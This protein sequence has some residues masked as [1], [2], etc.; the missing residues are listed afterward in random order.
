MSERLNNLISEAFL[1]Y[2]PER[3][4]VAVSGG[5]DS[6]ALLDLLQIFCTAEG[7]T[8]HAATVDHGL[9]EGSA[10]EA[11]IVAD[12]CKRIGIAHETLLWK[13]W[14]G[15][16]NLQAE[17]R[18]ARYALLA[19]WAQGLGID[20][21][22]LGHT[23]DDQAETVLMR[24]ARRA[25]VD[26][27]SAMRARRV[28]EGITWVRPLLSVR[29]RALRTYLRAKGID[30]IED[31]SN[32]DQ[33]FDRI[34]ARQ[35]LAALAPL[36]IDVEGLCEVA[37]QLRQAREALEWQTFITAQKAVTLPA[38][39]VVIGEKLFET[40]PAEIRRRL[41]VRAL[42]WVS[43]SAYPPRRAAVSAVICQ[44][45]RGQA[46]TTDGCHVRRIG[47][48]I[49]VFR[50]LNAVRSVACPLD[51]LWDNRW[52]IT[53]PEKLGDAAGLEIRAL[54]EEGLLQCPDW[55]ETAVPRVVLL[56]S[57]AVWRDDA[58]VAAP[59][60]G[61]GENW[62]AEVKNGEDAFFATLLSH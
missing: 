40:E 43:G 35:A 62:H 44:V 21:V 26:G 48:A 32:E 22:A 50:E 41:F 6:M 53:P 61:K 13:D 51:K 58:L 12:Q 1:P 34:K 42:N 36:E 8:L 2:P 52:R 59:L 17:A 11:A 20:T 27:L 38:G 28:R 4:G 39:A 25:G 10:E 56:S 7:I 37:D 24:L 46:G 31:P 5:G 3:I 57:P 15:E 33:I 30:W 54:G 55:R 23:A 14:T 19:R 18:K 16:G 45:A 60:A 29:R 9:R 47:G 49:W